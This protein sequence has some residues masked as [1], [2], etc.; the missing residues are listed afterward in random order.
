MAWWRRISIALSTTS[1]CEIA[2]VLMQNVTLLIFS[3]AID[4]EFFSITHDNARPNV[5]H[6]VSAWLHADQIEKLKQ[7]AYFPDPFD[8][9]V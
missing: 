5:V 1:L 6:L 8:G 4:H 3:N 9:S 2:V 7:P